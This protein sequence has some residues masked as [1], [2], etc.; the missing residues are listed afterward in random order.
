MEGG[1]RVGREKVRGR[2]IE[3]S[4]GRRV[5]GGGRRWERRW[6]VDG[7][8]VEGGGEGKGKREVEGGGGSTEVGEGEERV[9]EIK[10]R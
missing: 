1:W 7:G 2:E 3:G 6:R 5:E 9:R 4:G 8:E 10:G